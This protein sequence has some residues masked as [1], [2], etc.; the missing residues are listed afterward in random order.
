MT[1]LRS[2]DSRAGD[3]INPLDG[4]GNGVQGLGVQGLGV[5]V[6]GV[7]VLG[8]QGL[9]AANTGITSL[10]SQP[11]ARSPVM[12]N[13]HLLLRICTD[14]EINVVVKTKRLC[15]SGDHYIDF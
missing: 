1:L 3:I 5:Q 10:P 9:Q 13:I 2:L 14:T 6:L 11:S 15:L 7:Q 4:I 12:K 8:V